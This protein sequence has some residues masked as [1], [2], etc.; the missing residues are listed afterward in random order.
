MRETTTAQIADINNARKAAGAS[1]LSIH[2]A[3][4]AAAQVFAQDLWSHWACHWTEGISK[5][6]CDGVM[7]KGIG[8]GQFCQPARQVDL[9]CL[10]RVTMVPGQSAFS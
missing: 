3:L 1:A 2:P 7:Y 8:E 5:S 9:S 4:T 10:T 6:A